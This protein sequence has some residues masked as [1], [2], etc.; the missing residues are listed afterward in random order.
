MS[1]STTVRDAPSCIHFVDG[2]RQYPIAGMDAKCSKYTHRATLKENWH[3]LT[4]NLPRTKASRGMPP[5]KRVI[6]INVYRLIEDNGCPGTSHHNVSLGGR[7]HPL[8]IE[9][10]AVT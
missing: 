9:L 8:Y 1:F 10:C 2:E 7:E 3:G 5:L 4:G 6:R